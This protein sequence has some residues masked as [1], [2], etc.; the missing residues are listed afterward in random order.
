M[1]RRVRLLILFLCAVLFAAEPMAKSDET[2]R[3]AEQLVL[4]GDYQNA[5]KTYQSVAERASDPGLIA[6]NMATIYWQLGDYRQAEVHYRMSLDDDVIPLERRARALYN[7][8]NC[9]MK[10]SAGT[11]VRSMRDAIE[12]YDLCLRLAETKD[13]LADAA[14]NQELAK[15][16][17]NRARAAFAEPPTPNTNN[18][19]QRNPPSGTGLDSNDKDPQTD[20]GHATELQPLKKESISPVQ[21]KVDPGNEPKKSELPPPPGAGSLPVLPDTD[22]V[23]RASVSDTRLALSAAEARLHK[24]RMRLRSYAAIP[25]NPSG[26][27]W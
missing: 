10:L 5:L 4:D 19:P 17:W 6:F 14:H 23:V 26:K 24:I 8:G 18:P 1:T 25:E 27:D 11:E 12:C 16:L 20:S 7:L 9:L 2:I 22:E 15:I 3:E 21:K 13:L